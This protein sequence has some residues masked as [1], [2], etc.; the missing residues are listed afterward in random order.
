VAVTV[1]LALMVTLQEVVLVVVQPDHAEK[2]L[3]A[4]VCGRCEGDGGAGVVSARE[5]G[6]SIGG[7]VV[8]SGS[9]GDGDAGVGSGGIDRERVGVGGAA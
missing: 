9:D 6:G 8:V 1:V 5:A 2:L 7:G 3:P 4:A